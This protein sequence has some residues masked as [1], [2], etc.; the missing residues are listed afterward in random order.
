MAKVA[1]GKTARRRVLGIMTEF[2]FA[3][4]NRDEAQ[5]LVEVALWLAE[6]PCKTRSVPGGYGFPDKMTRE[7][8]GRQPRLA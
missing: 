1:V 2:A 7:A 5:S 4:Q 3:L 8:F 6:T